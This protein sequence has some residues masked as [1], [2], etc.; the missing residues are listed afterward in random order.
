MLLKPL[1]IEDTVKAYNVSMEPGDEVLY[2]SRSLLHGR[3]FPLK[4]KDYDY[5]KHTF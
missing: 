4:G 3:P 2:Q 1:P 5:E